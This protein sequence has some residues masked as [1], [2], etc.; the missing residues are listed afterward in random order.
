MED[1]WLNPAS[2]KGGCLISMAL[3]C[4]AA[5]GVAFVLRVPSSTLVLHL[6]L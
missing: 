3:W 4:D 5:S 1:V 6:W 2:A